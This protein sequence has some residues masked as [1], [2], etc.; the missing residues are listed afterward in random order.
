MSERLRLGLV[1]SAQT[2]APT[3]G[4]RPHR[5]AGMVRLM[6]LHGPMLL[7]R[8]LRLHGLVV[9]RCVLWL[10]R[11][12][13]VRVM[14]LMRLTRLRVVRLRVMRVMRLRVVWVMRVMRGVRVV[15]VVRLRVMRVG[16]GHRHHHR[17]ARGDPQLIDRCALARRRSHDGRRIPVR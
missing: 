2:A 6:R 3:A 14:R 7:H 12:M 8:T 16:G 15:R 1:L 9:M 4:G 10:R 11:V 17:A 13:R 5:L